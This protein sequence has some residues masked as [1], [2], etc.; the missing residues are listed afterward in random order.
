MLKRT[1]TAVLLIVLLVGMLV[2]SYFVS[3]VF[4]DLFV[5]VLLVIAIREM[6]FCLLS[7]GYRMM[8]SPLIFYLVVSYPVTYVMQEYIPNGYMGY[9]GIAITLAASAL[10][11]LFAFT[12]SNPE[13]ITIKD[14]FATIFVLIYPTF[15]ISLAWMLTARYV[16]VFSILFAVFLPVGADTFAYWFGSMIG[17]KK[18]CPNISPKKTVAGFVGGLVGGLVVGAIF[19]LVFE[20][21]G[22]IPEYVPFTDAVWKSVLI[23]LSIGLVG[24]LLGQ[25]GDLA[26]SRIKRA[27][28]IKDFGKLFPGHGGVMDRFDSITVGITIL[29]IALTAIYA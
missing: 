12:L 25:L 21:A 6:Y 26:A 3:R 14:L 9:V 29:T 13:K 10:I 22:V 8:R 19:Y 5:W 24:A 7:A 16:A 11:A 4:I 20:Y 27:F 2:A 15:F 18:L 28:D 1:V 23:Y 17:G